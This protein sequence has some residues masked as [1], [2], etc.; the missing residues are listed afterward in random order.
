M[1]DFPSSPTPGQVYNNWTW[2]GSKWVSAG[3]V[4]GS[5]ITISDTPPGSPTAG[6]M[7]WESD[8]GILWIYF[9]DVNSSQ[10]VVANRAGGPTGSTGPAG[11][12]GSTGSTGPTGPSASGSGL[13]LVTTRTASNSATIDFISVL[14]STYNEYELHYYNVVP[15]TNADTFCLRVG[16]SGSII[17]AASSY[18][19]ASTYIGSIAGSANEVSSTDTKITLGVVSKI[20]NLAARPVAGRLTVWQPSVSGIIKNI[21]HES[22]YFGSDGSF[23]SNRGGGALTANTNPI[24]SLSF[25][26]LGGNITTGTFK[27]YGRV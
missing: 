5:S 11:L 20:S 10:W 21:M 4:G 25:L 17:S 22:A 9:T 16:Q 18:H 13:T 27:L 6:S 15:A 14:D 1:L 8:T 26:F 7:W 24:D 19:R 2:D 12:T 23:T 3:G